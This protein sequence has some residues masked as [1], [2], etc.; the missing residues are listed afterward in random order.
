MSVEVQIY[1]S[2]FVKFF[3]ENPKE[4]ASVIGQGKPDDF[5]SEVEK[6]A[7]ENYEKGEDVEL[8]RQQMIDIVLRINDME[9]MKEEEV[10][11][12][13]LETSFGQIFLN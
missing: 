9:P 1:V 10:I 7:Y 8:T 11:G 12:P 2:N 13:I 3:K 5:F 4:L 6:A